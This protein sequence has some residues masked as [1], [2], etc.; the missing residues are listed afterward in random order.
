[1]KY[2]RLLFVVALLCVG[3]VAL[4]QGVVAPDAEVQ[5]Y[6]LWVVI[7]VAI[8]PVITTILE[9]SGKKDLMKKLKGAMEV[10]RT[11]FAAIEESESVAPKVLVKEAMEAASTSNEA[12]EIN[13]IL[14]T[15]T[16]PKRRMA[17]DVPPIKRFWRRMLRG[18][19]L[20]GVALRIGGQSAIEGLLKD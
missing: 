19:N 7:L 13:E 5:T 1:M 18:Q 9:R 3:A 12:K 10:G 8:I 15:I 17:A 16:D 6:P 14:H 11:V 2:L 20:A 4:A